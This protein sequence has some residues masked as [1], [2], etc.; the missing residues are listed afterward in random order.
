M[1]GLHMRKP[2]EGYDWKNAVGKAFHE[3]A[4][5]G[6][7]VGPTARGVVTRQSKSR[8]YYTSVS[9]GAGEAY[10]HKERVA[11]VEVTPAESEVIS[12]LWVRRREA[13]SAAQSAY[14]NGVKAL[15]S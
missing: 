15:C 11:L 9:S 7:V 1:E 6:M 4:D 3:F 2:T 10:C 14:R 5:H 13:I 12:G 8:I